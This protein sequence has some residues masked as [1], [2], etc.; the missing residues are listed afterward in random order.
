MA[1]LNGLAGDVL[2]QIVTGLLN[3][4]DPF[5]DELEQTRSI[6]RKLK[7]GELELW[8]VQP[9]EQGGFVVPEP[10]SGTWV[11]GDKGGVQTDTVEPTSTRV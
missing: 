3:R 1:N 7:S 2:G 5:V 9:T 6:L 10:R 11:N 8:Q 4:F